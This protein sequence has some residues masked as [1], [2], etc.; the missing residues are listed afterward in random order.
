MRSWTIAAGLDI[1]DS[2]TAA[3]R[4]NTT[5][6]LPCGVLSH[7]QTPR[8]S[9]RSGK[10]CLIMHGMSM[11]GCPATIMKYLY[12]PTYIYLK[13]ILFCL[14]S[15][16]FR[17]IK[18]DHIMRLRAIYFLD[19]TKH[20]TL[21][22]SLMQW[23]HFLFKSPASVPFIIISNLTAVWAHVEWQRKVQSCTVDTSGV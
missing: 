19:D 4:G 8:A 11:K 9:T 16:S 12:N 18:V 23:R 1:S 17:L 2:L 14:R 13:N 21:Q 10:A 7:T 15:H 5:C 6:A 22:S 20:L 3:V